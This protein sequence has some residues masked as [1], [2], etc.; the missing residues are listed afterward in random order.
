MSY[1]VRANGDA[2]NAAGKI[3]ILTTV[4]GLLMFLLVF[5]LNVGQTEIKSVEAQ[6]NATTSVNVLNTP[7]EFLVEADEP[8]EEFESST[9]SPTNSG[10]VVSFVGTGTDQN[11]APYFLIVCATNAVTAQSGDGTGVAAPICTN[12]DQIA[13]SAST[14]SGVEARAATTTTEAMPELNTWYAFACDDDAVN[15]ECSPGYQGTTTTAS[16]FVV[17]HRPSFSAISNDGPVNPGDVLTFT[18]TASDGDTEGGNDTIRLIVCVSNDYST[19][20]D[21][22]GAAGTI[23]TST[24]TA[25]NASAATT[26]F[27]PYQDDIYDAYVYVVDNHGHEAGG[28]GQQG[29]NDQYEIANVAPTV[30]G[31]QITLNGGN[32]LIL[33]TPAGQT[34]GFTLS[35]VANDANS[36]ENS[37]AGSEISSYVASVFRSGVGSSSCAVGGDYDPNDCYPS[38]VGGAIWAVSCTATTTGAGACGGPTD[39]TEL[40]ECTFPLWYVADP[41]DA[42]SVASFHAADDWRA[43]ISAVDDNSA[44]SSFTQ[45]TTAGIELQQALYFTLD[46][47]AIPYGSL[48]PGDTASATVQT[49]SRATGNVGIDQDLSGVLMCPEAFAVGTCP[50]TSTSSIPETQQEY[51]T[52]SF[53]YGAGTDLTN[54]DATLDLNVLKPTA[55]STQ[56]SGV[57]HWLLQVPGT[58]SLAGAYTGRNSFTAVTSDSSQWY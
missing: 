2:L 18:S 41:T 15:P 7:P 40:W 35:F 26:T 38:P 53:S 24:L 11:G 13:I 55:T 42:G 8:Q 36:C 58:I 51:A 46:D 4:G 56:T 21:S 47:T 14:T 6:S 9:G 39:A 19:S 12:N 30:D 50:V 49:V 1:N 48:A 10:D 17:N 54:V 33:D 22:C 57:T 31:S 3:T 20:T 16:P 43:A 29:A 44:T 25:S 27:T 32:N 5:L 28:S 37:A 45:S 52:S 34:T 23:A